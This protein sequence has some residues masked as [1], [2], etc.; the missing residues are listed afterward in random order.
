[1]VRQVWIQQ[2]TT[3]TRESEHDAKCDC[4]SGQI[5]IAYC[6]LKSEA[7]EIYLLL[8]Y[9]RVISGFDTLRISEKYQKCR[10]RNLIS[11]IFK[12]TLLRSRVDK[13]IP[14]FRYTT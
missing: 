7:R 2:I 9:Q 3:L 13:M 6:N 11:Q 8:R 10:Y 5:I 1:M 12:L 4:K 14:Q